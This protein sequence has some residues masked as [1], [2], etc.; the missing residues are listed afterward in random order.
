MNPFESLEQSELIDLLAKH[1][2]RYSLLRKQLSTGD[3][4]LECKESI[5]S[6]VAEIEKRRRTTIKSHTDISG[7]EDNIRTA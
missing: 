7:Q 2:L 1:L 4:L 6:L 5:I 3:Q